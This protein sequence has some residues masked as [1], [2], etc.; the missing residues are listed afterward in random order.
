MDLRFPFIHTVAFTHSFSHEGT[1]P[2]SGKHLK[3]KLGGRWSRFKGPHSV[4]QK[5]LM[6][7]FLLAACWCPV[8]SSTRICCSSAIGRPLWSSSRYRP[9][10]FASCYVFGALPFANIMTSPGLLQTSQY[11]WG[12]WGI[13]KSNSHSPDRNLKFSCS[14]FVAF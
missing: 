14:F 8:P 10:E 2:S 13:Q 12:S 11:P 7:V 1:K 9:Q 4:L 3:S 5:A 6:A